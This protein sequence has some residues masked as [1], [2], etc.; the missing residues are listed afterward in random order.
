MDTFTYS[1]KFCCWSVLFVEKT[2]NAESTDK[3]LKQVNEHTHAPSQ[4]EVEVVKVKVNIKRKAETTV[5][6][7]QEINGTEL[8]NISGGDCCYYF[9]SHVNNEEKYQKNT[10][11]SEH[12]TEF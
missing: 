5:E 7:P 9:K 1:T 4:T 11:R 6:K 3:F 8:R 10:Q 12:T 2:I